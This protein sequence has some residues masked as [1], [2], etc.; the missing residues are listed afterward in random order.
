MSPR[1]R[2]C[3]P[4]PGFVTQSQDLSRRDGLCH[5][6]LGFATRPKICHPEPGFAIQSRDLSPNAVFCRALPRGARRAGGWSMARCHSGKYFAGAVAAGPRPPAAVGAPGD[7]GDG[8]SSQLSLP[9]SCSEAASIDTAPGHPR[10]GRATAPAAGDP[11]V[12]LHRHPLVVPL[13]WG[14]ERCPRC[15]QL[16]AWNAHLWCR[17]LPWGM[18]P[19]F[20]RRNV[21]CPVGFS[22]GKISKSWGRARAGGHSL[23]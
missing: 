19:R 13:R 6:E 4:E 18:S 21:L 10:R 15:S 1:A 2:F 23:G 3:H 7:P 12:P 8:A 9:R 17:A 14:R 22:M 11:A 16:P 20:P 5:L